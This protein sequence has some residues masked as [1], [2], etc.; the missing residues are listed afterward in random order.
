MVLYVEI[1][2]KYCSRCQRQQN[3]LSL[4][5][6]NNSRL[7]LVVRD[8]KAAVTGLKDG[9]GTREMTYRDAPQSKNNYEHLHLYK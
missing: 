9:G 1:R 8:K 4:R 7:L 2:G 5:E 3:L 6:R